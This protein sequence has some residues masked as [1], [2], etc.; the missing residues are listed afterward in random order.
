MPDTEK[1]KIIQ[2]FRNSIQEE[3]RK[4]LKLQQV[5]NRLKQP[6]Y[7]PSVNDLIE[8]GVV[9]PINY[10]ATNE[11]PYADILIKEHGHSRP[12]YA[13]AGSGLNE[14]IAY[15]T[16]DEAWDRGWEQLKRGF[17]S[18]FI[19]SMSSW[20]LGS[21]YN[22]AF[23]DPME[24]YTNW[25]NESGL[26]KKLKDTTGLEIWRD[27][28][29]FGTSKY[30][31]R[32]VGQSGYTL[33]ILAEA[34]TEQIV[35][36]A[37]T[38]GIGNAI[39][40]VASIGGLASKLN[41]AK[42]IGTTLMW[43]N[44]GGHEAYM[45][46]LET[47]HSV[48]EK[49]KAEG[50]DEETSKRFA[51]EAAATGFKTE[52][53]PQALLSGLSGFMAFGRL[54]RAKRLAKASGMSDDAVRTYNRGSNFGI[55]AYSD[56]GKEFIDMLLPNVKNNFLKHSLK[57]ATIAGL[58]A[59]EEGIQTGVGQFATHETLKGTFA[60]EPYTLWN[61][62]MRDSLIMGGVMGLLLGGMGDTFRA[63]G[64]RFNIMA[65]D[66][67]YQD[68]LSNMEK[69]TKNKMS[70]YMS[71]VSDSNKYKAI[72]E[73]DPDN[74]EAKKMFESAEKR[75]LEIEQDM[76]YDQ[77]LNA[78]EYDYMKG[79]GTSLF[80]THIQNQ[81][82]IIDAIENN[83][84]E[85]LKG[86]G[87][88]DENGK[89]VQE[90]IKDIFLKNA[91][92]TIELSNELRDNF[93]K[94]LQK[95][96]DK[97]SVARHLAKIETNTDNKIKDFD[98]KIE[99]QK[100]VLEN[101]EDVFNNESKLSVDNNKKAKDILLK[102]LFGDKVNKEHPMYEEI[103]QAKK[104]VEEEQKRLDSLTD[105]E[106]EKEDSSVEDFLLAKD[107]RREFKDNYIIELTKLFN[108][109]K[110]RGEMENQRRHF[111]DKK[112][113][114]Q[115][116]RNLLNK[117]INNAKEKLNNNKNIDRDLDTIE[118]SEDFIRNTP[119]SEQDV[120]ESNEEINSIRNRF[121]EISNRNNKESEN[122][123]TN[124]NVN[125][126]KKNNKK[127]N[128]NRSKVE[129]KSNK[130][131]LDKIKGLKDKRD[132][133]KVSTRFSNKDNSNNKLENKTPEKQI[134]DIITEDKGITLSDYIS[135]TEIRMYQDFMDDVINSQNVDEKTANPF[136]V[137]NLSP[138]RYNKSKNGIT[139]EKLVDNIL[140]ALRKHSPKEPT[141]QDVIETLLK[142]FNSISVYRM[143]D[144]IVDYMDSQD[145]DISEA[146]IIYEKYLSEAGNEVFAVDSILGINRNNEQ[147]SNTEETGIPTFKQE[148]K[149][150]THKKLEQKKR[151]RDR[152]KKKIGLYAAQSHS[153]YVEIE[154][155]DGTTE[156]Q[157]FTPIID[158][159]PIIGNQFILDPNHV[160]VGEEYEIIIPEDVDNIPVYN[161]VFDED[162]KEITKEVK[163]FG[164]YVKDEGLE[165]GTEAYINKV[166]MVAVDKNGNKL[167]FLFDTDWFN[168]NNINN[169]DG[170]QEQR[171]FEGYKKTSEARKILYNNGKL[172]KK[173]KIEKRDFGNFI[174]LKEVNERNP[175]VPNKISVSKASKKSRIVV[176]GADGRFYD[177]KH[178]RAE[179]S[180][181]G[182]SDLYG[183]PVAGSIV[184]L[185][186][187][188]AGEIFWFY[189][190]TN[191][192][193]RGEF[194]ND[195]AYN[196]SKW[197]I[198]ANVYLNSTPDVKKLLLEK[199]NITE[200][201]IYNIVSGINKS[202][203][204]DIKTQLYEYLSM[205]VHIDDFETKFNDKLYNQD[206]NEEGNNYKYPKDTLYLVLDPKSN[207]L[208]FHIKNDETRKVLR[209]TA[210]GNLSNTLNGIHTN[211]NLSKPTFNQTIFNSYILPILDEFF[212]KNQNFKRAR[213]DV[214]KKM[215]NNEDNKPFIIIDSS[216]NISE[217][218]SESGQNSYVGFVR[219]NLTTDVMSYEVQTAEGKTVEVLDIV[220]QIE[221]S[222]SDVET[223]TKEE[224]YQD[225]DNSQD[226][227]IKEEISKYKKLLETLEH[228]IN[229]GV[230]LTDQE[231]NKISYYKNIIEDLEKGETEL[232]DILDKHAHI[233]NGEVDK[234]LAEKNA[235]NKSKGE[236]SDGKVRLGDKLDQEAKEEF[237]KLEFIRSLTEE[238]IDL[239][240]ET[241]QSL[242]DGLSVVEQ[243]KVID[244][245]FKTALNKAL[246]RGS[247]V[248][249]TTIERTFNRL[250][251]EVFGVKITQ[252][253]KDI[254]SVKQKIQN[255]KNKIRELSKINQD[256]NNDNNVSPSKN[257]KKDLNAYEIELKELEKELEDLTI[258]KN[259][260]TNIIKQKNKLIGDENNK[261]LL[262]SKLEVFLA[263]SLDTN[264]EFNEN[265]EELENTD[266][267]NDLEEDGQQDKNYAK[268][269]FEGDVTLSF[270]TRLKIFFSNF[271]VLD[272]QGNEVTDTLG[273]PI[274]LDMDE[275]VL[276]LLEVTTESSSDIIEIIQNLKN[277]GGIYKQIG[278]YLEVS[279]E[280]IQNE[281][282]Y[283]T[284][285]VKNTMFT[286]LS[287][288]DSGGK[289][290]FTILNANSNDSKI[291]LKE[292]F[293]NN[294]ND[295]KLFTIINE[296]GK[297][298]K[299][300]NP[301]VA[302]EY[303]DIIE[304][305]LT[306]NFKL[307]KQ[308]KRMSDEDFQKIMKSY[309]DNI[310]SLRKIFEMFGIK[311]SEEAIENF[312]NTKGVLVSGKVSLLKDIYDILDTIVEVYEKNNTYIPLDNTEL[313]LFK[314]IEKDI[315]KL[316]EEEVKVGT[317]TMTK[318]FRTA[319]KTIN[320][321][322]QSILAKESLKKIK[323]KDSD[324]YNQLVNSPFSKNNYLLKLIAESNSIIEDLSV[325]FLSLEAFKTD[326]SSSLDKSTIDKLSK[327][328]NTVVQLALFLSPSRE[329]EINDGRITLKKARMLAPT[330]SDKGHAL[331]HN[332]VV[333]KLLKKHLHYNEKSGHLEVK[334]D[335]IDFILEQVFYNE[336]DR[337]VHTYNKPTNIS[338]YDEA[339]KM[340]LSLPSFN[341]IEI[342]NI[343]E[344]GN[345]YTTTLYELIKE[346]KDDK[347]GLERL[348]NDLSLKLKASEKV[349]NY[350][351][352]ELKKKVDFTS[353]QGQWFD[354]G[355]L[356]A[357]DKKTIVDGKR[358]VEK[359]YTIDK[360]SNT[361]L[362]ENKLNS[363]QS[364][365][366]VKENIEIIALNFIV[367]NFINQNNNRQLVDGDL[368]LYAPKVK[369]FT[370]NGKVD[371]I[372]FV[373]ALGV[374]VFKREAMFIAPGNKLANSKGDK[375]LQ[376]FLNDP[377]TVTSTADSL[378]KQMYGENSKQYKDSK[379]YL[380]ELE[381]IEL[382][383]SRAYSNNRTV[384]LAE[385]HLNRP[386]IIMENNEEREFKSVIEAKEYVIK[387]LKNINKKIEGFFEIEGTDA[388]EYTTWQEHMDVIWRQ[389]RMLPE[390]RELYQEVYK[391]LSNGEVL[392]SKEL[393]FIMQPIKPVYT[394]NNFDTEGVNRVVYIKSSSVPLLPQLT[395]GLKIDRIRQHMEKLQEVSG[396]QVRLSYQTANKV[397]SVSTNLSVEDLY[398][399]TFEELYS[400]DE[401]GLTVG[402]LS[403]SILTLDREG[404]RVQQD[405]PYKTE[406]NLKKNSDDYTTMGVQI[407]RILMSQGMINKGQVF[408]NLFDK[409]FIESLGVKI[410]EGKIDG[411]T[412]DKIKF[413]IEN[414]Y[415]DLKMQKALNQFGIDPNTREIKD[416]NFTLN[417]LSEILKRE[418]EGRDFPFNV[419]EG[420]NLIEELGKLSLDTPIWLSPYANKF[421]NLLQSI[422]RT[423]IIEIKLPGN[424]HI[425]ASSEGFKKPDIQTMETIDENTRSKIVWLD[426]NRD[427]T[428]ELRATR[429]EKNS[430]GNSVLKEAEVLVQSKFRIT[431]KDGN[432]KPYT[433]LID[434]TEE[435][436]RDEEGNIISG[437]SERN[438]ET[439]DLYLVEDRI[440][441]QLL[442]QFSFRIPTSS[443]QSGAILK[444][445]GFLPEASGDTL[446]VPKEHTKQIGEDYDVDKR[447]VY[448]Y[449]YHVD[450]KGRISKITAKYL[451]DSAYKKSFYN[452]LYLE[453]K[454]SLKAEIEKYK[455][456]LKGVSDIL[457]QIFD[458][459][460]K[461]NFKTSFKNGEI[462]VYNI[463]EDVLE[464]INLFIEG[465]NLISLRNYIKD[466]HKEH[467]KEIGSKYDEMYAKLED[468]LVQIQSDIYSKLL[469]QSEEKL[470]ENSMI[471]VYQSVYKSTDPE[472]QNTISE[473][474]SFD[475][476]GDTV[477]IMEKLT[478]KSLNDENFS[479]YSDLYQRN[480]LKAGSSG[481]LGTA[482]YSNA[483]TFQSL[484]ERLYSQGKTIKFNREEYFGDV[485]SDGVLGHKK[486]LTVDKNGK[487][488]EGERSVANVNTENQNSAVDNV[489]AQIMGRRNETDFT[490]G[491]LIG[492]TRRRIDEYPLY[493]AI[494]KQGSYVITESETVYKNFLKDNEDNIDIAKDKIQYSSV[495]LNQPILVK[496]NEYIENSQS[497]LEENRDISEE[498]LI[499]EFLKEEGYKVEIQ[500][501]G[502]INLEHIVKD[503]R[504]IE[505]SKTLTAEKLLNNVV[506]N[507]S[508]ALTDL[509]IIQKFIRMKNEAMYMTKFEKVLNVSSN[510]LGKSYF[511]TLSL[512]STLKSL[513]NDNNKISGVH[514][515]IGDVIEHEDFL[516]NLNEEDYKK[517]EEGYKY[518]NGFTRIGDLWIKPNNSESIPIV[519]AVSFS[520]SF[521]NEL[522]PFESE[523]INKFFE[524][525]GIYSNSKEN[526][527]LKYKAV[528]FLKESI[529]S[530]LSIFNQD[531]NSIRQKI[532]FDT[533]TN[534]SLASF[535]NESKNSSNI[536]LRNFFNNNLFLKDLYKRNS[537][538]VLRPSILEHKAGKVSPYLR[539]EKQQAI[540]ELLADNDT[541]LGVWNGSSVTPKKLLEHLVTY[542]LL[543]K[544]EGGITN[545]MEYI[546][547]KMLQKLG[548]TDELRK[549]LEE[550][551]IETLVKQ[552]YQAN[553][554]KAEV[555][556]SD[557]VT[558]IK[559]FSTDYKT[560]NQMDEVHLD[561]LNS[562][563]IITMNNNQ[564]YN[565][566][567][568]VS[569]VY[570]DFETGK[571]EILL[572]EFDGE[573]YIRIPI[574]S[575]FGYSELNN[576][577]Y[578]QET[579]IYGREGSNVLRSFNKLSNN[580]SENITD[581]IEDIE[582]VYTTLFKMASNTNMNSFN[583][584]LLLK[585]L[586]KVKNLNTVIEIGDT[587]FKNSNDEIV[588][589]AGIYN[590]AEDVITISPNIF[591]DFEKEGKSNIDFLSSVMLEEVTHALTVKNLLEYMTINSDGSYTLKIPLEQTPLY[592][593]NIVEL[594]E[595]A[596]TH[597]KDNYYTSN[598]KE[599]VAGAF[600]DQE[601]RELLKSKKV[602]N[603]TLWQRFIKAVTNFL[604]YFTGSNYLEITEQAIKDLIDKKS[605]R[606]IQV[607][608]L[609]SNEI[610]I[611]RRKDKNLLD[612]LKQIN[613]QDFSNYISE[614]DFISKLKNEIIKNQDLLDNKEKLLSLLLENNTITKDC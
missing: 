605:D 586:P 44:K 481:K 314:V 233:L 101:V 338:N 406:K 80:D 72:L 335:V 354:E 278:E 602:K 208:K 549:G 193:H 175:E 215:L 554:Y 345:S 534:Q 42:N 326:F 124:S 451:K 318:S 239:I 168:E 594:Y 77:T 517:T 316:I 495:F 558:K 117:T 111:F 294:F 263:T 370:S 78:L 382:F 513:L 457:S 165:E 87:I 186:D 148:S 416:F 93:A 57:Y 138:S 389:G 160:K 603:Q 252:V 258:L 31:A 514:H 343:D 424:Q 309:K 485:K 157:T 251:E 483:V 224:V 15:Q 184:E 461:K 54:N 448:K 164:Q 302:K 552:F 256:P 547:Y 587:K 264:Q 1:N 427:N 231:L 280:N 332:T 393:K 493:V 565:N 177:S 417:K 293:E 522:F 246:I 187:N 355:I 202:T 110:A 308:R 480:Q 275:A 385:T 472:I 392:D 346:L 374:N 306:Y 553:P 198:I 321:T 297:L 70:E 151:D 90:G 218:K 600:M 487:T 528:E 291:V 501:D 566:K 18:G 383:I 490:M 145:Y 290:E 242:I 134:E 387:K 58:E 19:E 503:D 235:K 286:V 51:A 550:T 301:V 150:V 529:F 584:D 435:V 156:K 33:G 469:K 463:T 89:E 322:S 560:L 541:Y 408:P 203:S 197:A 578:N 540:L 597:I 181:E 333:P 166:P 366:E 496:L 14:L 494:N 199:Y 191:Q 428:K 265:V 128:R 216:G 519:N 545:F 38:G 227:N 548:V 120:E 207:M 596:K 279:D 575:S 141:L 369:K 377:V 347:E 556:K 471:D 8:L 178:N 329:I 146:E 445:V 85:A 440:D 126:N 320:A 502:S 60:E 486:T 47:G 40:G 500:K 213:F 492:L 66:K 167:F 386:F 10:K 415:Y 535:I 572:F 319:G 458:K 25:L 92:S 249:V 83:D 12:Y 590:D 79:E 9:N 21:Q 363:R 580:N 212:G 243:K 209:T 179:N 473:I 300:Y 2:A 613:E 520:K 108:M 521:M 266:V 48:Y 484:L 368:A 497:L 384:E 122:S 439:G 592:I 436:V 238:E 272:E 65:F 52:F 116:V 364:Q 330:L 401:S 339:A 595:L 296:N 395:A 429:I 422:I 262:K 437:Y 328:D 409:E 158:M 313:N 434:L 470:L 562:F 143:Y 244:Y 468:T 359:I 583:R 539:F 281:V 285:S 489:K 323:D 608:A 153:P 299:K 404:F 533:E 228:K 234:N 542:S 27:G 591:V 474:L 190:Q 551:N 420:L 217:Y 220:P 509:V 96:T 488:I 4:N 571:R 182:V 581:Y 133:K 147:T 34:L 598:I 82:K 139:L 304:G 71:A 37:L 88:L 510:G 26:A 276:K 97:V 449:N 400:I 538:D 476:A 137:S 569:Y 604:R 170:L 576:K 336:F 506:E 331:V 460:F 174:S 310:K 267:K 30:W 149:P 418:A 171:I 337:I 570:E 426:K 559:S 573:K 349:R 611:E 172:G 577:K 305:F 589:P 161:Y 271:N 121:K 221:Y 407:W 206:L 478:N 135:P 523:K 257:Q 20:D 504:Y 411:K 399:S 109:L 348:R 100:K 196:N 544:H 342:E 380:E 307:P 3:N 210:N 183:N 378:V 524:A 352:S 394:G 112:N 236:S 381:A 574:L 63:V 557:F 32:M 273:L 86:L 105:E 443:H 132:S 432:G 226:F 498:D 358:V 142:N 526:I 270:S 230:F 585:L 106:Y 211:V 169:E 295:S 104:R 247:K 205:F 130:K 447:S 248:D 214:S 95:T 6:D 444:V 515:L 356:K 223:N 250:I 76:I 62:E 102:A 56:V 419:Q 274:K 277:K 292:T 237:G 438:P 189:T 155:G 353:K 593:R 324:L 69:S 7:K 375:Y 414:K 525:I 491:A 125:N 442:S 367:A 464:F 298:S 81:Q 311:V 388:Q 344:N 430:E 505:I 567:K 365:E 379:Q 512:E 357:K 118:E 462:E 456:S 477:D 325:D 195:I 518:I 11:N 507:T 269:Q 55:K 475:T 450:N 433:E 360:V 255:R 268:T 17:A 466:K 467:S 99:E 536:V 303:R 129:V 425:V 45:N 61:E 254:K 103:Q 607:R 582:T 405:T 511:E 403:K 564:M 287:S 610:E 225:N 154:V 568:F 53:I 289:Y 107:E 113:I 530:S 431:K 315:K 192:P 614:L 373:N 372:R 423:K 413:E 441:E 253:R 410:N 412:L 29:D 46:A 119:D 261:S 163:T 327:I 194:L 131:V 152:R 219:D 312:S 446:V 127:N 397:G 390:E 201:Q 452:K 64:S 241:E 13:D 421:E 159:N 350:I 283:K 516:S 204:I 185:R 35:L 140:T 376:I 232:L 39:K 245:L 16:N 459:S 609:I 67:K 75:I 84:E 508:D 334:Q 91:K 94:H 465:D 260:L 561:K 543:S 41:N 341:T 240:L 288:K 391:K 36:G 49:A 74:S 317:N 455:D 282:L 114:K 5:K 73:K 22:L 453:E 144:N 579:L 601:F 361:Y 482:M 43:A 532:F 340:F 398:N 23:G 454:E 98:S 537:K 24:G 176:A 68:F 28:D 396:K 259:K 173:I 402:K 606:E 136:G 527:E 188:G 180:I 50:Y 599:F 222:V 499:K 200:Q 123:D 229:N 546:P 351:N 588:E 115:Y 531:V 284:I 162:K 479:I 371:F 563:K 612:K 59:T 362:K 555:V